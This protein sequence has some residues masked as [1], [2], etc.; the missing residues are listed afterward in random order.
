MTLGA[1]R[2]SYNLYADPA[3]LSVWGD[4][5]A[6][7]I[8]QIVT[9]PVLFGNLAFTAYGRVPPGQFVTPGVYSDT[10]IVTVTY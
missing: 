7:S 5:T 6:G 2:L 10:I 9:E 4:D 1:S 3:L 8:T